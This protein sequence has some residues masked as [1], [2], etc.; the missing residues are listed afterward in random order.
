MCEVPSW[1][2]NIKTGEVLFLTDKDVIEKGLNFEDCTGHTAIDAIFFTDFANYLNTC[3]D[4]VN[5][6]APRNPVPKE[7]QQAIKDGKMK[8]IMKAGCIVKIKFHKNGVTKF[9]R[10]KALDYNN[11]QYVCLD[12][13]FNEKGKLDRKNGP[14]VI[15][16]KDFACKDIFY[17]NYFK[18]GV[19]CFEGTTEKTTRYNVSSKISTQK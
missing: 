5:E 1:K 10:K 2:R 8:K 19:F 9:L 18:D 12:K 13:Y 14:A 6:E 7:V 16:Y 11:F 4:W 17:S 3:N 15:A